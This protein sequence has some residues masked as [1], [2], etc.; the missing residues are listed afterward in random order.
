MSKWFRVRAWADME[1]DHAVVDRRVSA[2]DA[3]AA[4]RSVLFDARVGWC[5]WVRVDEVGFPHHTVKFLDARAGFSALEYE[6][7]Y[8]L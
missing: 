1:D 6:V 7:A 3:V 2:V 4:A 5:D 8:G